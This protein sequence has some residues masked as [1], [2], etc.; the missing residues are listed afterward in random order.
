[1]IWS[2]GEMLAQGSQF[3]GLDEVEVTP[4]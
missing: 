4:I 1:M 3:L 2:N